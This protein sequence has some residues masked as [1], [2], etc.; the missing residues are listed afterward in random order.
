MNALLQSQKTYQTVF[1]D[2]LHVLVEKFDEQDKR[3][4]SNTYLEIKK[5]RR[6]Y[7]EEK[8]TADYEYL[9]TN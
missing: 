4:L 3:F 9:Y 8:R 6:I 7:L 1:N 5:V 2:G